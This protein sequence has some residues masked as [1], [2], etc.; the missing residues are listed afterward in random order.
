MLWGTLDSAAWLNS[1]VPGKW[2][3]ARERLDCNFLMCIFSISQEL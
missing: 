2:S 1:M 3:L